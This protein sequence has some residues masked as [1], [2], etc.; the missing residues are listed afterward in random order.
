[1]ST[2]PPAPEN[3]QRHPG[4]GSA[5]AERALRVMQVMDPAYWERELHTDQVWLSPRLREWTGLPEHAP[6]AALVA[7]LHADDRQ[8]FEAAYGAALRCAGRFRE[9]VRVRDA[10]GEHRWL[11]L[12]GRFLPDAQGRAERVV[13]MAQDIHAE[14]AA[15]QQ[16]ESLTERLRRAIEAL[17]EAVVD[18]SAEPG[19]FFLSANL[20]RLLG[21][22]EGTAA[23]DARTYLSWV[24]PDDIGA[25]REEVR[26]SLL[27]PRHW[28]IAYRLRHADGAYRWMRGRGQSRHTASGQ[29]RSVGMICDIHEYTLAQQELA[30]HREHLETLVAERTT[31]LDA[32][33]QAAE[34][35]RQRAEHADR[36]KS[37]FLAHMSHEIRTPLNGLLG[38]TELALGGAANPAQR[39]YLEVALQS[40]QA[41]LS[42]INDVLEMSRLEAGEPRLAHEPF[43]VAEVLAAAM[44][45]TAPLLGGRPVRLRFDVEGEPTWVSGDA[46]RLRQVAVN[47]LGN[48]AKFTEHGHITLAARLQQV[49]GE[50]VA[51]EMN[52]TDTGPGMPAEVAAHAFDA[53][54]QGD[55]SLSRRHGGTGLGLAI[56]RGLAQAM[57]GEL[58]VSSALGAGSTFS[59]RAAFDAATPPPEADAPTPLQAGTAWLLVADPEDASWVQRRVERLGWHC[60]T[61]HD[62]DA[63]EALSARTPAGQGPHLLLS[64]P[65]LALPDGPQRS[66]LRNALPD[67]PVV[68]LIRADWSDPAREREAHAQ[69]MAM[70]LT[71]LTPAALRRV[72]HD[73]R[74]RPAPEQAVPRLAGATVLLVE[75]NPV[76]QVIGKLLL[77]HLGVGVRSAHDGAQ[78]VAA[79]LATAPDLV[80]MDVSMPV[81]DGLEATRRLRSLQREGRLPAF[82]VLGLS[83]HALEADRQAGLDAGM[84][85][86]V[87]K[88][89]DTERLRQALQRWVRPSGAAA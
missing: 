20:P 75:D 49:D 56:A 43:D 33:L 54:Y 6:R 80:I 70:T 48:A 73:S 85:D 5:S 17:S 71:P 61:A 51:L 72:L 62:L 2:P 14:R 59:F 57:G 4:A 12:E 64:T 41:L 36:A 47:L 44:R 77:E 50:R 35:A 1:M 79:C 15:T 27:A 7:H 82:P 21:Y 8:R 84:D 81:M 23:P 40:G 25:L 58:T 34:Q 19:D 66:R 52:V 29:L 26:L 74:E 76:N 78:A 65:T 53:F 60:V 42:V 88:P 9:D 11:R 32:A 22:P 16:L 37:A 18:G 28:D 13:G 30:A 39:R 55:N 31:R 24:H 67:V 89:V 83:A 86:Y 38:L 69:G 63:L 10:Q 46:N 68:L 3:A 45:S 87:T